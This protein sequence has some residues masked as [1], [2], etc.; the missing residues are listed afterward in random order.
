MWEYSQTSFSLKPRCLAT[1]QDVSWELFK[2]LNLA[3]PELQISESDLGIWSGSHHLFELY[4]IGFT[5]PF[6]MQQSTCIYTPVYHNM[7]YA[8]CILCITITS[9][10]PIYKIS[11][12]C[13]PDTLITEPLSCLIR[14]IYRLDSGERRVK[15]FNRQVPWALVTQLTI[16]RGLQIPACLNF[17]FIQLPIR[18]TVEVSVSLYWWITVPDEFFVDSRKTNGSA[19]I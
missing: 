12:W 10:T 17:H 3:R 18:I 7:I 13:I 16:R 5:N 8:V 15:G 4:F 2:S 1:R 11:V 14:P 9:W 6:S 19:T